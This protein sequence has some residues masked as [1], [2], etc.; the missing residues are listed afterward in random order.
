MVYPFMLNCLQSLTSERLAADSMK[1]GMRFNWRER[2][3]EG[4]RMRE[5]VC[6]C[7]CERE[8]ERKRERERYCGYCVIHMISVGIKF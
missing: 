8:R 4:E 6:V 2:Y 3:R 5:C 1:W 7:V